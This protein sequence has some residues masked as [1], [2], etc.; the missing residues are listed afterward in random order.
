MGLCEVHDISG[1][2]WNAI[3][4]IESSPVTFVVIASPSEA[5]FMNV[6]FC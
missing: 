6:Q 2:V 1:F 5:E 3:S 4:M